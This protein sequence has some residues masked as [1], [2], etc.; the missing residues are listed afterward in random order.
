MRCRSSSDSKRA[1]QSSTR[2][3][4]RH[5]SSQWCD[6][7]LSVLS[8]QIGT[9]AQGDYVASRGQRRS[10]IVTTIASRDSTYS[11]PVPVGFPTW[12]HAGTP[13][14]V[15]GRPWRVGPSSSRTCCRNICLIMFPRCVTR[16]LARYIVVEPNDPYLISG[17]NWT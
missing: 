5:P 2:S 13:R 15:R 16:L 8:L 7:R 9:R 3:L 6:P 14:K 12:A 10:S 17:W 4:E 1:Q 11:T